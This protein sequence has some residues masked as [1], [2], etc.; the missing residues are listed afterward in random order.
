[1]LRKESKKKPIASLYLYSK[2]VTVRYK[3]RH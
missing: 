1:M 2:N 3:K